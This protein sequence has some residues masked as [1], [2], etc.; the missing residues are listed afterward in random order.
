MRKT[1]EILQTGFYLL[2]LLLASCTD[3]PELSEP[4]MAEYL[5]LSFNKEDFSPTSRANMNQDGMGTFVD[6]DKV[7]LYIHDGNTHTFRILERQGGQWLPRISRSELGGIRTQF[8]ALYPAPENPID[9]LDNWSYHTVETDQSGDGYAKSDLLAAKYN[10][11][12]G[13]GENTLA[14]TFRHLM[15]RLRITVSGLDTAAEDFSIEVYG[16]TSGY[17]DVSSEKEDFIP[18]NKSG[19]A[20]I[21][22]RR[23]AD[24]TFVVLL[25]PQDIGIGEKRFKITCNGKSYTADLPSA[26][27]SSFKLESGK[28]TTVNLYFG[29][30]P[31]EPVYPEYAN[32]KRW[33]YGVSEDNQVPVYNEE[34]VFISGPDPAKFPQGQWF[35]K[36][37][38]ENKAYLL[39]QEDYGWYD[40][41]KIDP[42]VGGIDA[43]MCWAASTSNLLHW[44]MYHN[45]EYIEQYEKVY[46]EDVAARPVKRPDYGFKGTLDDPVFDFFRDHC[47]N[48]GSSASKGVPWFVGGVGSIGF[49]QNSPAKDMKGFF[50]RVF[51]DEYNTL[52]SE[53][54][55]NKQKFNAIVR[56]VLEHD[57]AL[58][59]EVSL[60]YPHAMTIWG[61]EFDDKGYVSAIYYV[62]NN[63]YYDLEMQ[64]GSKDF[65][66][67]N[68]IRRTIRY[69]GQGTY[70]G[71]T[72]R[73]RINELVPVDLMRDVWKRWAENLNN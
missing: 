22:P 36:F 14:M 52:P 18:D 37:R 8:T 53:K 16:K 72:G 33:I 21:T 65:Q 49:K 19:K 31:D 62:D 67:H 61:F 5:T 46:A 66:H 39:W 48:E 12:T 42:N 2:L 44:W 59:F 10:M 55:L 73:Q 51:A 15:H 28:E 38:D 58:G 20:W 6:G 7:G 56:D 29:N 41:D 68:L 23:E 45:R 34:T 54:S 13:S 11:L 25:A 70:V 57:K 47:R 1:K 27:G 35:K 60:S 50:S 3:E 40:C 9:P 24:G 17:I 4:D 69:E 71:E 43:N 64:G 26:V 30:A 32:Q 63:D